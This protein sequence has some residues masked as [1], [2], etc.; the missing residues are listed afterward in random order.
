MVIK[1][2]RKFK[3]RFTL[4]EVKPLTRFISFTLSFLIILSQIPLFPL[5]VKAA[6]N[7]YYVAKNGSD[8][9]P[10]SESQPWLTIQKAADTMVAGDTVYVKAGTYT[11]QVTPQN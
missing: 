9:N 1:K 7:I 4:L 2:A 10:G 3:K 11:E 6:P 8:S 5:P